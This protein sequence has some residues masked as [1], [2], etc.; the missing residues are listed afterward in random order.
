[1]LSAVG[2]A[3]VLFATPS[4]ATV[5]MQHHMYM[6]AAVTVLAGDTVSFVNEDVTPHTITSVRELESQ[7]RAFRRAGYCWEI[8]EGEVGIACIAAPVFGPER[9]VMA[10]ISLAGSTQ[11]ITKSNLRKLGLLVRRYGDL[12]SAKL[13]G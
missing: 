10:A 6:P 11:Q 5:T 8:N 4:A 3:A 2:F 12:M 1:M 13:G 9:E 7:F